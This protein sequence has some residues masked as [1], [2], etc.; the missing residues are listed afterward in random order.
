VDRFTRTGQLP[1]NVAKPYYGDF[2][3][4]SD[5]HS[6]LNQITAAQQGFMQLPAELRSRFDNDPGKLLEF[7]GDEKNLDEAIKLGLVD[8]IDPPQDLSTPAERESN[9]LAK[10]GVDKS[11]E[12]VKPSPRRIPG[13]PKGYRLVPDDFGDEGDV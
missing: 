11:T 5:Y 13:L 12:K 4:I 1:E 9:A 3:G 7:L 10:A 6:A 8:P 2:T